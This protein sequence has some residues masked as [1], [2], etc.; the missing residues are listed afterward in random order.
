M[1]NKLDFGKLSP[2][3]ITTIV[4]TTNHSNAGSKYLNLNLYKNDGNPIQVM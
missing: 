3:V 4:I 1:S 2:G